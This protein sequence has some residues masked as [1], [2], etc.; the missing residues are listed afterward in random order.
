MRAQV[1]LLPIES[2]ELSVKAIA[3]MEEVKKALTC[4]EEGAGARISHHFRQTDCTK[5]NEAHCSLRGGN[6]PWLKYST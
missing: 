4:V 3:G 5:Y 6:K 2:K 1:I